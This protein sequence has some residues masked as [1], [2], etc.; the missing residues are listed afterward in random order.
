M[1]SLARRPQTGALLVDKT[2][3]DEIKRGPC[4]L[5]GER[6][7]IRHTLFLRSWRQWDHATTRSWHCRWFS[8]LGTGASSL[9][10]WGLV[11][12]L[13]DAVR[14]GQFAHSALGA[15]V[16]AVLE[17]GMGGGQD[18]GHLHVGWTHSTGMGATSMDHGS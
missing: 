15:K 1:R 14:G 11:R 5:C 18:A 12:A 10:F 4:D 2:V 7:S 8:D 17:D 16:V 9:L 3:N 6:F 13:V